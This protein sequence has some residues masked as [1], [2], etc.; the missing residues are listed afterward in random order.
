MHKTFGKKMKK[1]WNLFFLTQLISLCNSLTQSSQSHLCPVLCSWPS[2][3]HVFRWWVWYTQR[4]W[5]WSD[6]RMRRKDTTVVRSNGEIWRWYGG[7]RWWAAVLTVVG[8]RKEEVGGGEEEWREKGKWMEGRNNV[9][10]I[11]ERRWT[12]IDKITLDKI[13]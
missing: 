11:K 9:F 8:E 7:Q 12:R 3:L 10:Q 4:R 2:A 5:W 6:P 13:N 1:P